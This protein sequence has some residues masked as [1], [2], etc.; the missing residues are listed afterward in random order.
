LGETLAAKAADVAPGVDLARV[1]ARTAGNLDLL[2]KRAGADWVVNVVVQAADANSDESGVF[3]IETRLLVQVWDARRHDW[4]IN[5]SFT[6]QAGGHGSP[7]MMFMH[8]LDDA[9]KVAL[10]NLVGPY[11]PVVAVESENSL[12]DYLAG[13]TG[14]VVGDPKKTVTGSNAR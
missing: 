14:P 7:V 4:L 9:T 3:K 10:Q 11:P 12:V 13:Q 2:A 5:S 6:G 8:S 1:S